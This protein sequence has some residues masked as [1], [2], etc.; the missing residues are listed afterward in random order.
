LLEALAVQM[1]RLLVATADGYVMRAALVVSAL[2]LSLLGCATSFEKLH[3]ALPQ[4]Q[5][6]DISELVRY[7][8]IP[9][10]EYQTLGK[11]VYVWTVSE[12]NP[13]PTSSTSVTS[14][15]VG[16]TPFTATTTSS[17]GREMLGCTLRVVTTGRII[18]SYDVSGNNGPCYRYS[19]RLEQFVR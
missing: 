14:G 13:F 15:R 7:L 1:Y 5:G 6:R 19:D 17:G 10:H 12:A 11:T 9:S 2:V 4:F 3:S 8:G 18:E 16:N